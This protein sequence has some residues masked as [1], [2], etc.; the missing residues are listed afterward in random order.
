[1]N[2]FKNNKE[3]ENHKEKKYFY[4]K[5]SPKDKNN[6]KKNAFIQILAMR[7][8]DNL[9]IPIN[10]YILRSFSSKNEKHN[11]KIINQKMQSYFDI[12]PTKE[13]KTFD[14][15]YQYNISIELLS[16]DNHINLDFYEENDK[17]DKS[18]KGEYNLNLNSI[19]DEIPFSINCTNSTKNN[20]SLTNNYYMV[21]YYSIGEDAIQYN[22]NSKSIKIE[23]KIN[24]F[25]ISLDNIEVIGNNETN[26]N[27]SF[28]FYFNLF[29]KNDN[30][31][32]ELLEVLT[33]IAIE[34]K[35]SS[36]VR[37]NSQEEK[38]NTTLYYDNIQKNNAYLIQIKVNVNKNNDYFYTKNLVYVSLSDPENDNESF[39]KKYMVLIIIIAAVAILF[40]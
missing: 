8:D 2:N 11:F 15:E 36:K 23:R 39:I 1:L 30:I 24:S 6:K 35:N 20:D 32:K 29:E 13:N 31:N 25:E 14:K 12:D 26:N 37:V 22:F 27:I 17:I 18:D 34:P 7:K 28:N 4:I 19:G 5:I 33:P 10:Q 16:N 38:I 21:R 9:V 3:N 40:F